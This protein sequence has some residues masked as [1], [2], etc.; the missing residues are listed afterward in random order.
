MMNDG[1]GILGSIFSK[2]KRIEKEGARMEGR[3]YIDK[4]SYAF[5]R[6]EWEI[7]PK[8]LQKTNDYPLYSGNWKKNKYVVNYRPLG[9]KWFFSDAIREGTLTRG[10]HYT[11]EVK[12]T[13]INP[14]KSG[15]LPYLDR[16]QKGKSFSRMT[17]KYDPDFWKN[18]NT[19]PLNSDLAEIRSANGKCRDGAKS[20]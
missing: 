3:I 18:Y 15:P 7:T 4:E 14:E 8:G 1:D 2:K 16:I 11:N 10:N 6:A 12:I 13:D 20:I 9:D 5:I 17:G 19:T